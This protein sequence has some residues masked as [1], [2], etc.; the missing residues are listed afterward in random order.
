MGTSEML[1]I[2]YDMTC[3]SGLGTHLEFTSSK[4]ARAVTAQ[5]MIMTHEIP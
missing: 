1:N 3:A 5:I 4:E 2:Q